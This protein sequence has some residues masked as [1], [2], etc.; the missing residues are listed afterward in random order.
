LNQPDEIVEKNDFDLFFAWEKTSTS[1][2][3]SCANFNGESAP[4]PDSN[5]SR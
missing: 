5:E 1:A 2:V 3:D 4:K